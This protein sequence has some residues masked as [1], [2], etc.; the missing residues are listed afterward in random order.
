MPLAS[1]ALNTSL[2]LSIGKPP[3]TNNLGLVIPQQHPAGYEK[4][5][6]KAGLLNNM[7]LFSITG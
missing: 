6:Q 4:G 5:R 7:E 1:T 2:A 3:I